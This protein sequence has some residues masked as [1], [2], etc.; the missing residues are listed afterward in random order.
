MRET[1]GTSS[2][3]LGTLRHLLDTGLGLAQNRLELLSL[4]LQEEKYRLIELLFLTF[5]AVA[6][7]LMAL[8]MISLTII[9]LFW[10]NGRVPVL[11]G[12]TIVYITALLS[13]SHRLRLRLKNGSRPLR[14]SLEELKK[15]RQCL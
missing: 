9:V 8:V 11:I 15:D 12:L 6:F 4:E 10:E 7:G 3:V 14:D 5:T 1:D 13:V 2:G